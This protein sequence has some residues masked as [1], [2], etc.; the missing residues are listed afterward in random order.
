MMNDKSIKLLIADDHLIVRQGLR[1]LLSTKRNIE[2]VGES[3]D[4]NEAVNA[5]EQLHPNVVLM[6]I[7]MPRVDGI[8]ATRAIKSKYPDV[9]VIML[10]HASEESRMLEAFYA[11]AT[12]YLTKEAETNEILQAIYATQQE[13]SNISQQSMQRLLNSYAQKSHAPEYDLTNREQEI[14][15]MMIKGMTNQQIANELTLTTSTIKFHVSNILQKLK[16]SSRTE[17]VSKAIRE[18]IIQ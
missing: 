9:S 10:T 16:V 11:G 15:R 7:Q 13:N 3:T 8:I 2:I 1:S 17:A 14:L 12:C 4:G 6:D 18:K 5:V